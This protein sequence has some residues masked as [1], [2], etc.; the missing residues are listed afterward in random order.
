[1]FLN[2]FLPNEKQIQNL[3]TEI[4]E[5]SMRHTE[6]PSVNL[7]F[8]SVSSVASFYYSGVTLRNAFANLAISI[9]ICAA[10]S[11]GWSPM[12]T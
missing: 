10:N 7:C 11:A 4:T 9:F 12:I 2:N 1:M 6:E 5:K 3:A 8:S